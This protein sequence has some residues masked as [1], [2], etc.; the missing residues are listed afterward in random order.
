LGSAEKSSLR[1][2]PDQKGVLLE[3]PEYFG[4][5]SLCRAACKQFPGLG[6]RLLQERDSVHGQAAILAREV[7]AA[8]AEHAVRRAVELFVFLERVLKQPRVHSEIENLVA[9]S[10]VVPEELRGSRVG[11]EVLAGA[12][13]EAPRVLAILRAEE[14]RN[15]R[16]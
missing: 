6:E 4:P 15:L 14:E 7:M 3:E 1:E 12:N 5:H 2:L 11:A 10:F 8:V 16:R 9:I 13:R